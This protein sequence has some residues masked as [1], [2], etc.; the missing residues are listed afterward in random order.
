ML[1]PSGPPSPQYDAI[2]VTTL[3]WTMSTHNGE[4]FFG[5]YGGDHGVSTIM[6]FRPSDGT[7]VILL[8]N[9]NM[10]G[11]PALVQVERRLFQEAERF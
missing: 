8:A 4:V 10:D 3:G 9:G 11:L 5:H 6:D 7:G 2:W 1:I